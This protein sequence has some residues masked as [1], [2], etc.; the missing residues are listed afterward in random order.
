[1]SG[2]LGTLVLVRHGESVGNARELFSGVLDVDLTPAGEEAC[3]HAG[4]RL[5]ESGWRPDVIVTSE[6]VRGWRTA[7]LVAGSL[8]TSA[9]VRRTW[10]LNERS[11]GALSGHLKSDILAAHGREQFLHWRRSLEG[12]P[13]A[14]D[15][16][17]VALWRTL[18]PFD[19]LPA[20]ALAATESLAD[21]VERIHPWLADL[22]AHLRAGRHVLVV[23]HGNSL[24]ALC[25]LLDDLTG[26]ELRS[27]NLPNARPLLYRMV[28]DGARLRPRERG[29]RYLDPELARAEAL[30]IAHQ[31]GT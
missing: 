28:D 27:L 13:P 25:A 3:H 11:Y 12:R 20:E 19:R 1:M 8:G 21:V 15:P 29:G 30:L 6:L 7:Q 24:R 31:G 16:A 17:V 18:S 5:V 22:E 2:S 14:L 23:A 4:Q 26:A 9:P 10:R